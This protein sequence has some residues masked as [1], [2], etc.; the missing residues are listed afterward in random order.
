MLNGKRIS[1]VSPMLVAGTLALLVATR[2]STP[3]ASSP[4]N[5]APRWNAG[6]EGEPS[7][8]AHE[9]VNRTPTGSEDVQSVATPRGAGPA[10]DSDLR[11][12]LARVV[13]ID[14]GLVRTLESGADRAGH[15]L[16]REL[17]SV[18]ATIQERE[19]ALPEILELLAPAAGGRLGLGDREQNGAVRAVYWLMVL[20]ASRG[21]DVPLVL[22]RLEALLRLRNQFPEHASLFPLQLLG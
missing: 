13:E 20:G 8:I 19:G 22:T 9:L 18:L 14:Q 17:E 4:R 15:P 12:L 1:T 16:T 7:P 6:L 10:S 5:P 11:S 21:G 2:F 3:R